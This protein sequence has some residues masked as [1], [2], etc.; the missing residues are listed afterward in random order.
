GSFYYLVVLIG[1][2]AY[3]ESGNLKIIK[4]TL[5][6]TFLGLLASLGFIYVQVFII[7]S[8]C[9]YCMGSAI[10]STIL[11][12]TSVGIINSQSHFHE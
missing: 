6:L 2:F 4:Q 12:V 7:G 9:A 5:L 3:L 11:F 1:L 10:T 8:Y